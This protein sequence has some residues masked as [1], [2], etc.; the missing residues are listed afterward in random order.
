MKEV[1]R[2][3]QSV[4]TEMLKLSI[5]PV[6]KDEFKVRQQALHDEI[7]AQAQEVGFEPLMEALVPQLDFNSK[8][9][10]SLLEPIQ[11]T[12][13]RETKVFSLRQAIGQVLNGK[14]F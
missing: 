6:E 13:E 14:L 3:A 11:V 9:Q 8:L 5:K 1:S 7:A 4:V 10:L 2:A 12:R